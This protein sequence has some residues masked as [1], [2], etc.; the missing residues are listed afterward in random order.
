MQKP[1]AN[2]TG[3]T[4]SGNNYVKCQNGG[5]CNQQPIRDYPEQNGSKIQNGNPSSLMDI[6]ITE[7]R[8]KNKTYE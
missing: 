5:E 3:Y 4:W 1:V 6:V 8:F 7:F 2:S